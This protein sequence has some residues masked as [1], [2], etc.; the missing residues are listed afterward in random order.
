[1]ARAEATQETMSI[2]CPAMRPVEGILQSS[3]EQNYRGFEASR[4]VMR[5]GVQQAG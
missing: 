5:Q 1:M 4:A 3:K 2:Q